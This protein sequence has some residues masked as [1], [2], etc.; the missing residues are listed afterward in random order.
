MNS[1]RAADHAG[2]H[3]L[4]ELFQDRAVPEAL[5]LQRREAAVIPQ[6]QQHQHQLQRPRTEHQKRQHIQELRQSGGRNRPI[7]SPAQPADQQEIQQQRPQCGQHELL[8][9]I[10]HRADHADQTDE[11]CVR[12]QQRQDRQHQLHALRRK[13]RKHRRTGFGAGES[14]QPERPSGD[15]CDHQREDQAQHRKDH[16]EIAPH[17]VGAVLRLRLRDQ[18]DQCGSERPLPQ[19]PPE[20]VRDRKGE[21]PRARDAAAAEHP[22]LEHHTDQ[23]ERPAQQRRERHPQRTFQESG[24]PCVSHRGIRTGKASS[25]RSSRGRPAPCRP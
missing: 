17:L 22:R 12:H 15:Q 19:Q 23:S 16:A 5:P 9:G 1:D 8:A 4:P 21:K 6:Q 7:V 3:Q 2:Q 10:Q 20:E 14:A 18:R 11:E 13:Q 24:L 25:V